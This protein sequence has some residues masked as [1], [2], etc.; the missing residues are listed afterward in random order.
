MP[1][2]LVVDDDPD[3]RKTIRMAL[4]AHGFQVA[5]A[6][7]GEEALARQR[8][9]PAEVMITDLFMP[10]RD[11][12]ETIVEFRRRFPKTRIIAMSGGGRRLRHD[13]LA[14]AAEFG[15]E[16]TFRKPCDPGALL[17]AVRELLASPIQ[18]AQ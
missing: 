13:S 18:P 11:G 1:R 5:V 10:T 16:R 4:E 7:D 2:V 17:A 9:R 6:S 3:L 15:A 14:L 8:E 12:I